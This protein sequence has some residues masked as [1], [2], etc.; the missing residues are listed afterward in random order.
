MVETRVETAGDALRDF[1]DIV[2]AD[3]TGAKWSIYPAIRQRCRAAFRFSAEREGELP[4]T[5]VWSKVAALQH[6]FLRYLISSHQSPHELLEPIRNRQLLQY[7]ASMT[8]LLSLSS[9]FHPELAPPLD[10]IGPQTVLDV[11][12]IPSATPPRALIDRLISLG[13]LSHGWDGYTAPPIEDD[14]IVRAVDLLATLYG[15]AGQEGPPIQAPMVGP[16]PRG[17]IQFEWDLPS[18]SLSIEIPREPEPLS[19]YLALGD[20]A[21]LGLDEAT[22]EDVWRVATAALASRQGA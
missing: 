19:L 21:E 11:G 14:T 3:A 18:G 10:D 12:R 7:W 4:A 20:R 6:V 2:S 1:R 17:S 13:G 9:A 16:T 22:P 5:P 15:R 8:T